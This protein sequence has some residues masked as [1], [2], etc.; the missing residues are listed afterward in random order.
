MKIKCLLL[1]CLIIAALPAKEIVVG[2]TR[3]LT[4]EQE[5]ASFHPIYS[6][7]GK[8]IYFTGEAKTGL[9]SLNRS[10]FQIAFITD[11][12]GAGFHPTSLSDGSVVFR[13]DEYIN[14]RKYTSLMKADNSGIKRLLSNKR[15]LATTPY[16]DDQIITLSEEEIVILDGISESSGSIS[17]EITALVNDKLK[18][19]T[20]RNGVFSD[21]KPLGDGNYIWGELSPQK[22][23]IVFTLVGQGTY[24]CDL[25]GKI[26]TSLGEAHVP[27]WSPDGQ[28]LVFMK[29]LDDGHQFTESEIWITTTDG[30]QSWK[31]TDTPDRIELYPRWS[32]SGEQIAYHSLQGEIFETLI[33]SID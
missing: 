26:L 28:L 14:G 25:E 12:R 13:Q 19:K 17:R 1:L 31:I 27:Q 10:N 29:D 8:S 33:T 7:D 15:F 21:L 2:E 6:V 23:M 16:F 24:I 20:F 4:G 32:P 3:H 18:L 22:D 5:S 9:W 11:A 30:S